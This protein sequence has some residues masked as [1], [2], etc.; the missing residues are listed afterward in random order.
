ML[1]EQIPKNQPPSLNGLRVLVVDDNE[2]CLWLLTVTFE[3]YLALTKTA[4]S[5]DNAIQAI[6]EWKPDIVLSE[7]RMPESD[8]YSLIRFMRNNQAK[9]REFIPAVAITSYVN[10]ELF[11]TAMEAGFQEVIH[12]PFEP[13]KLVAVVARLTRPT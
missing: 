11:N 7:I 8:D 6:E 2:D 9:E 1:S 13:D 10:P 12:K 4:T 5:V 3:Q